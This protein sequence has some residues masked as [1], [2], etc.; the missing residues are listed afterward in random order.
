MERKGKGDGR[1][2]D[3][4]LTIK[5]DEW[6][7]KSSSFRGREFLFKKLGCGELW[8][9]ALIGQWIDRWSKDLTCDPTCKRGSLAFRKARSM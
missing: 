9:F 7:E 5:L 1:K 4:K 6:E 2:G 3:E 8:W